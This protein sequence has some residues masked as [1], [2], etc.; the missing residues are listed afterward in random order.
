MCYI[1]V[2]QQVVLRIDQR[3]AEWHAAHTAALRPLHGVSSVSVT[4]HH[5]RIDDEDLSH[6]LRL[7]PHAT[8]TVTT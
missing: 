8:V 2:L 7:L 4:I 3:H 1:P 6:A 5:A